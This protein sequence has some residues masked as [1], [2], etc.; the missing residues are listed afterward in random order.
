MVRHLPAWHRPRF[1]MNQ[2]FN[3]ENLNRDGSRIHTATFDHV[4]I[5]GRTPDR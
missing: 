2:R 3:H 5:S 1:S 4:S